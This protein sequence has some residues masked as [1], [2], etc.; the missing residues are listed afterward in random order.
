M[1]ESGSFSEDGKYLRWVYSNMTGFPSS[2]QNDSDR[3]W[4]CWLSV[5]YTTRVAGL[6]TAFLLALL[7]RW[8]SKRGALGGGR[9][10]SLR[11]PSRAYPTQHLLTTNNVLTTCFLKGDSLS[12]QRK[13]SRNHPAK[14]ERTAQSIA[15]H[16]V[17]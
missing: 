15:P 14:K 16:F 11:S 3:H 8:L 4:S 17:K 6:G 5:A 7:L 2:T 1:S 10:R 12:T 13:S 9:N